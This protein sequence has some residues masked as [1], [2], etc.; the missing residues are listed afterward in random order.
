MI[1]LMLV[2][3]VI[4]QDLFVPTSNGADRCESVDCLCE[5]DLPEES[6]TPARPQSA[7]R[8]S[9]YFE[10]ASHNLTRSDLRIISQE[11]ASF[12][13][14][15]QVII[16]GHTDGC[17]SPEFNRELARLRSRQIE[18]EIRRLRPDLSVTTIFG[19]ETTPQHD[20]RARRVDVR[21]GG[22]G[23]ARTALPEYTSDFYL[24]DSSGSMSSTFPRLMDAIAR[25]KKMASRIFLSRTGKCKGGSWRANPPAGS[26]EIW[27]SYWKLL[28]LMSPG[29]EL[30]VI[31]DFDSTVPLSAWERQVIEQKV[32]MRG[33]KVKSLVIR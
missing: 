14:R 6:S 26:T 12:P 30:L 17:G 22:D 21:L 19:G 15:G 32:R 9:V 33:V 5:I 3:F 31:S 10:E 20:E 13:A 18:L 16:T 2:S 25:G 11:V 4:Q 8:F 23:V 28:D 7:G 29:D 24:V 1:S 27:Y